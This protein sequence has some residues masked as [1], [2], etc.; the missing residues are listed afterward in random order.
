MTM[1]AWVSRFAFAIIVGAAMAG[2]PMVRAGAADMPPLGRK[3]LIYT[4]GPW[5]AGLVTTGVVQAMLKRL[6]YDVEL[7]LVDVGLAYQALGGGKAELFSSAYLPGQQQYLNAQAGKIDILSVSYGPVPGGL[8][9]PAYAPASTIEDLKRPEIQ[10]VFNGKIVGIDAGAGVMAQAKRVIEQYGLGFELMPSSDAAMAASFKAAYDKKEPIIVTGYCPHYLCAL[11]DV[12][13]LE[14]TKGI[15]PWSQDYH[16]VRSGF[17]A[18]FP[19]AAAYLA[20]S[21]LTA[22]SVSKML[23][24]METEKIKPEQ[25]AARFVE[26]NP[27]L[28]WY[29]IGDLVEGVQ[30]PPTL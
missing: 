5:G 3:T 10:K 1:T 17:R 13:F 9:V 22:D 11:Y 30:K 24:W 15:Y 23:K 25:A 16:L 4:H 6:G 18:D 20:R 2:A 28:V 7:K 19:R 26:Q 8:M 12:K 27:E 14:D 29:W 21:T